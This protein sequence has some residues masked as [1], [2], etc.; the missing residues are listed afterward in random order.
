MDFSRSNEL[1]ARLNELIPG[2]GHTYAKAPDQFP[3]LSP[4]VISHGKG[5]HVWDADGN[6]FI[7]YGM[8]LRAVGLGHAY[9]EVV[10]A[11]R[12]SLELGTNFTR[13]AAIEL[14]CAERLVSIVPGVDMVK[15][16]KDG[17]TAT[18]AALKLARAAT[19][20]DMVAVCREHVFFSYDDWF[21][22]TTSMDGGIPAATAT[23]TT[24]FSYNDLDSARAMFAQF[25][26]E[27]AA[28]FLEPARTEKPMPGFLEGL[29][30]L[31]T[32]YGTVLVFDEM[33]T[34]FRYAF[35]GAQSLYG[36]QPDLSTW[37]KSLANGFSV[38]ALCGTR[39]LMRLGSRER[40]Q[41]S[42][43]LLS[44]TH[45]A[46][47]CS[48]AAAIATM[49]VYEREPVVEHL[50]RQGERLI[51]GIAEVTSRHGL[52]AYVKPVGFACNL[53]FSTLDR[54]H[55]PSQAMRS[56]FLQETIQRGVLAPSLVVS[57]SHNDDDID[58]TIEAI[59][60]A[61]PMYAKALEDGPEH[62]LVGSSS[63]VVLA[64]RFL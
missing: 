29:R 5:S 13:P 35:R 27:I 2:G 32:E 15:F 43:F 50:Y 55:R 62:F 1:K 6:E 63:R 3:E 14:E 16:T 48:L 19:G 64:R 56:L 49:Q 54:D 37:G 53:L 9:P 31:C 11:V 57:Y 30:T 45:G 21:I 17:S 12:A 44:T 28:V 60:G 10:D 51:A 61:L 52:S 42:V 46:E 25:P 24:S 20:R 34:G 7:E 18:S 38:S 58:R 41:D 22:S 39:D 8:G 23:L 59:D 33:I 4:G 47:V 26:D 40:E 36:V